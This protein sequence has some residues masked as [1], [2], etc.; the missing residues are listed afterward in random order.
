M[1]ELTLTQSL[2]Y[3]IEKLDLITSFGEISLV[4]IFEELNVFDSILMPCMSGNILIRDSLGLSDK[5][6]F[7]GSE[8]IVIHI[9]KYNDSDYG[10]FTKK[11]RIYKQSDRSIVNP[12]S[13]MYILHFVSEE[14]IFSEQ[15]KISQ[16]YKDNYHNIVKS[17]LLNY[18]KVP[19]LTKDYYVTPIYKIEN[20]KGIHEVIIPSLTPFNAIK[21]LTK[22]SVNNDDLPNFF[23][24]E[25]V[26]GYNFKSLT[27]MLQES[28]V[29]TFNYDPKNIDIKSIGNEFFGIRDL[30]ILN[31]YDLIDTTKKGVYASKFIGFDPLTRKSTVNRSNFNI[32]TKDKVNSKP[33][34]SAYKN[35]NG[36]D[37]SSMFDSARVFY[38]FQTSRQTESYIKENDSNT[39][40]IIDDTHI[41]MFQRRSIIANLMQSRIQFSVPGDFNYSC[42]STVNLNIPK[43]SVPANGNKDSDLSDKALSGKYLIASA[44][45][46]FRY[47]T[48][49]TI[50][51]VVTNSTNRE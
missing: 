39:S 49:E 30:K 33:N 24:F 32:I 44:R 51:E 35:R 15:Q 17:I 1:S 9:T 29:A 10:K 36:V 28:V 8:V 4:E 19:E 43:R 45:H 40:S 12:T 14:F 23:F 20:S 6:S 3:N 41:Y 11:F 38:P 46:I 31:T 48:H 22:R 18:L 2:Q 25:N 47:R 27:K 37:G 42:G 26:Y 13:E 50:M 34:L 5:L 7:D 21:W 16:Y